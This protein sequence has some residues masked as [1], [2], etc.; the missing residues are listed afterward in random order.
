MYHMNVCVC[1]CIFRI[2]LSSSPVG[3]KAR[4]RKLKP[5]MWPSK[6]IVNRKFSSRREKK[7][8]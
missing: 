4:G 6:T 5:R 3:S 7:E 8:K 2:I 1:V